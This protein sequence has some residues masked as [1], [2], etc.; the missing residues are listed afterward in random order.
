MNY[1]KEIEK[2]EKEIAEIKKQKEADTLSAYNYLI[3]K[4]F[5]MHGTDVWKVTKIISINDDDSIQ[6]SCIDIK[7]NGMFTCISMDVVMSLSEYVIANYETTEEE[8]L[9]KLEDAYSFIK[10][11]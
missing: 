4:F 10:N 11:S 5:K 9:L 7:M 6:V 1:D 8:Y 2:R 3:G